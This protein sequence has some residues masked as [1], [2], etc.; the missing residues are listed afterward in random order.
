MIVK[1][2]TVSKKCYRIFNSHYFDYQQFIINAAIAIFFH[3][4][5]TLNLNIIITLGDEACHKLGVFKP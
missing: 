4:R 5:P 2:L 1:I 3:K